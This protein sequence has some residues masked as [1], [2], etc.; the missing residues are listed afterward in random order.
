M[1][2]VHDATLTPSKQDLVV[3]W[4][5]SRPWTRG[6][7]IARKVGEYRFDDPAGEV[8]VETIIFSSVDGRLVQVPLT[9]RAE[10]LDGADDFLIGTADHSVLGP[11]WVY[12]GCGDPVWAGTL[13]AAILSGGTQARMYFHRDGERI[14]VPPRVEV[15][16][17]GLPGVEPPTVAAIDST[18][19]V[20]TAPPRTV[21]GCGELELALVR[22]LGTP[23]E[24]DEILTGSWTGG[25]AV[26]AGLRRIG[27]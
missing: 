27:G 8:G 9:Y 12:D 11:R 7:E 2:L 22:V 10:P 13:T 17:S 4:L 20:D 14:D 16:G 21:V 5:P 25:G 1:A 26:L 19:D 24:A 18:A 23:P 3:A 6:I 15:R